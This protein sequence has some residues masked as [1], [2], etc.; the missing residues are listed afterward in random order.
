MPAVQ[1]STDRPFRGSRALASGALTRGVLYGPGYRR[2]YPDI[3]IATTAELDLETWS[4]AAHELVAPCGV[5]AGYSAAE[6]HGASCA[7]DGA[8]AEVLLLDGYRRRAGPMLVVHLD[9]L[10][11]SEFTVV[12]GMRLATPERTAA[13]LARWAPTLTEAVVAVD[14]LSSTRGFDPAVIADLI[15]PGS[16]GAARV[17]QVVDLSDRASQSP[18]ETRVRLAIVLAGLP[19]PVSQHPVVLAGREFAFDLAY[20]QVK[21]AIEYNGADH[22]QPD[23]ALRDLEREQLLVAAG[24]RIIRF[25]AVT[26]LYHPRTIAARVRQELRA[27]A[28]Y[29]PDQRAAAHP[30]S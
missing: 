1:I 12:D 7:P 20:P 22:L 15:R 30:R 16:R 2:L 9:T 27:P 8:P 14:M 3:H 11:R 29:R 18:M 28:A 17:P 26:A 25:G 13:D 21:L 10:D 5:L 23:R 24:W 4:R 19:P 6:V